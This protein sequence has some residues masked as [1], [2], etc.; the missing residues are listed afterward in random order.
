MVPAL[1]E[2]NAFLGNEVNHPVFLG[3]ATRPHSRSEVFE[4]LRLSNSFDWISER[5]L[6]KIQHFDRN[7]SVRF[8]PIPQVLQKFRLKYGFPANGVS[9]AS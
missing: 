7:P 9:L 8:H 2:I 6:N 3:D 1:Q 5:C 4:S